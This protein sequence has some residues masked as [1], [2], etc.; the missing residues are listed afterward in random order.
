M[1]WFGAH[2]VDSGQMQIGA[3]TA[4]LQLPHADPDVGDDG[5][6]HVDDDPARRGLRRAHPE[7]L[8]TDSTVRAAD[9]PGRRC[10]RRHG[11]SSCAASSS[12]TPAPR[13]RCCSGVSLHAPSRARPPR[14]S[15]A[16]APARRRCSRWSR[17]CSTSPA[18]AVLVDGVDVREL[19]PRATLWARIGLVPQKPYLFTGTVATNL[20]YGNP[21]ATDEELWE[22]LEIAQAEDFV[23]RDARRARRADRP[24]R[25]QRLRRPAPAARDRPGAGAPS[26]RSTSSTTRSRRSTSPPTR[27]CARRCGRSPRDATVVIVAQ[28]VSTIIDADQI[29]VLEDGAVVGAGTHD[30]LL[31]TCPTYAEI[32]ESQLQRRGGGGMSERRED[33]PRQK[34]AEAAPRPRQP[35]PARRPGPMAD[36]ACRPRS[37][38]NFGPSAKR[39]LGLLR[40]ERLGLIAVLAFAVASVALTVDRPEDPR[41]APPTSSSPASSA[42][43]CRPGVTKEQA[44]DGARAPGQRHASPTCSRAWTSC[45]AQGIDFGALGQVLLLVLGALRRRQRCSCGCRADLLNGVVQR[46]I[47]RLRAR[48]RGQAQPAAA[49]LLRQPAARRAA[50]PGHQRHRQHRAD[51]C[52]RR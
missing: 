50:Q 32:V 3:L 16:P 11:A 47:C 2:R 30:E 40:P 25:H 13:R 26:R 14:S 1:L 8:D 46:T 5:D 12:A 52:S 7:V 27:G 44:V 43:S 17:G 31:E 41:A 28:R 4:F 19:R 22:A 18:G 36:R 29:V 45:P 34:A 42:S 35:A 51:A 33:R 39:L 24:G 20:R 23:A 49:A 9:Q 37:R 15:A 6:L 48:G 10:R 38:M 21:D